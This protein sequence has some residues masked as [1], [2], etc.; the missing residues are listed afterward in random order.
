M[1]A[2]VLRTLALAAGAAAA[3]LLGVVPAASPAGALAT[4]T[5]GITPVGEADNFHLELLPGEEMERR[6]VVTNRTDTAHH[7]RVYPVDATVTA[8]GGFALGERDATRSGV[9]AW[10][11][12]PVSELTLPPHS[13]APLPFRLTVPADAAPGDHA[14]GI[15]IE[16]DPKGQPQDLGDNF[17]VQMNLVERIGV[18]VY[19]TVAGQAVRTLGVG[20]LTWERSDEGIRFEVPVTNT[21]NVRLDPRG[22]LTFQGFRLP[23]AALRM[24]RVETLLP[25]STVTLTGLWPHPPLL[26]NG[27]ATATVTFADGEPVQRFTHLRLLPLPLAAAAL[28]G[29]ALFAFATWRF[30]RFLRRARVA[31]RLAGEQASATANR[32][33]VATKANSR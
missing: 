5:L 21:G 23:S 24:S 6:A 7:V 28:L 33:A 2:R 16:T 29:L 25:G 10:L 9:G 17:A 3:T 32:P 4:N 11:H 13:T 20:K 8:Q 14:G 31:L 18:R 15:V 12:L 30:V 22:E 27:T 26:A 19:L 1:S